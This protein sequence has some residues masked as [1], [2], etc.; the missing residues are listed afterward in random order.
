MGTIT[1]YHGTSSKVLAKAK[2]EN[3]IRGWFDTLKNTCYEYAHRKANDDGSIPVVI[4]AVVPESR[5]LSSW[6]AIAQMRLK[7][8]A[9]TADLVI[10]FKRPVVAVW[11]FKNGKWVRRAMKH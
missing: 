9:Y 6:V 2:R 1:I 4:E 5:F 7:G 11:Y 3:K 10:T 8:R